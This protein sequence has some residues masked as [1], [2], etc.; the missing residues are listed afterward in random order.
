MFL[1]GVSGIDRI[2]MLVL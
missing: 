1:H 2:T